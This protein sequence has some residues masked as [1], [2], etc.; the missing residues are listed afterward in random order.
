[1]FFAA[2]TANLIRNYSYQ[3]ILEVYSN[4]QGQN[5]NS[6]LRFLKPIYPK[7]HLS[8]SEKYNYL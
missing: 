3:Y 6:E 5:P 4:L 1:M 7:V 2:V 8:S